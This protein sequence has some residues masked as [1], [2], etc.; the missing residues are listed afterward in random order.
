MQQALDEPGISQG[1]TPFRLIKETRKSAPHPNHCVYVPSCAVTKLKEIVRSRQRAEET[2]TRTVV[3]LDRQCQLGE[4]IH[5]LVL[6]LRQVY[7]AVRA[8]GCFGDGRSKRYSSEWRSAAWNWSTPAYLRSE[9]LKP[10]ETESF[11]RGR[12]ASCV[13]YSILKRRRR[14][15]KLYRSIHPP[16]I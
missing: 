15:L 7:I 1:A 12:S 14:P 5:T 11:G 2:K 8:T 16:L 13:A 6:F 3:Q 9:V 4:I 10:P